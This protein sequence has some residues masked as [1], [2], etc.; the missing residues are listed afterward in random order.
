MC[1]PAQVVCVGKGEKVFPF[2]F[3]I[4]TILRYIIY[5]LGFPGSLLMYRGLLD[6]SHFLCLYPVSFSSTE[7]SQP[8]I[9]G[10]DTRVLNEIYAKPILFS[11][12]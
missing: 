6:N 1:W 2:F 9:Q 4:H 12:Y 10:F 5:T 3:G 7:L 11:F 8:R